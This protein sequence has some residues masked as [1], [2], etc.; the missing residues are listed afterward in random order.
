MEI[1]LDIGEALV[2]LGQ[3]DEAMQTYRQILEKDRAHGSAHYHLAMLLKEKG[4]VNE[5]LQH[6]KEA[7]RLLRYP[8][9]LKYD[10]ANLLFMV[11]QFVEANG[12]YDQFIAG[13]ESLAKAHN[14][15]GLVLINQGNLQEA[16]RQF[17]A[18]L[19]IDPTLHLA[20][21]N[22]HAASEQLRKK[23]GGDSLKEAIMPEGEGSRN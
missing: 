18:A 2:R 17:E 23:T 16:V 4:Q 7:D 12:K 20:A 11:G 15:K 14:N 3:L 22:L 5:A 10:Y 21:R 1:L 6:Y 13:G 19:R 8:S 9:D